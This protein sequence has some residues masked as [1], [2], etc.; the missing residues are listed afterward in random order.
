MKNTHESGTLLLIRLRG[1]RRPHHLPQAAASPLLTQPIKRN[2]GTPK[3]V[4]T[5]NSAVA[6]DKTKLALALAWHPEDY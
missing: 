5:P 4:F 3:G 6:A 1:T 2:D